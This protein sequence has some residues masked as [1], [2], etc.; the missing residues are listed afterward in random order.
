MISPLTQDD[1][2]KKSQIRLFISYYKPNIGL[3]LLDMICALII[4]GIDLTFPALSRSALNTYLPGKEF[5]A[6]FSIILILI[7]FFVLRGLMQFIVSYWGHLMGAN[8]EM[9]MRRDL[10]SHLQRQSFSFFDKSRTGSLMSRI[11]S[12]LFDI[13][14][15]AHHGPE[16]LFIS[17]VS[18]IGSFIILFTINV[19]LTLT[20]AVFLPFSLLSHYSYDGRCLM[21]PARSKKIRQKLMPISNQ[22]SREY[23]YPRLLQI[24]HLNLRNFFAEHPSIGMHEGSFILSWRRSSRVWNF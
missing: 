7:G 15:L 4:A 9:L 5:Q 11:M 13:T 3:F 22:A 8:I 19:E 21:L 16:D 6:F 23:A 1:F 14:E 2:R 12:D 24:N 17:A 18:I 20:L 10:F